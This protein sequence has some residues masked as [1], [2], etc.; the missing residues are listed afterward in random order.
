[1][2]LR[3][4]RIFDLQTPPLTSSFA[5]LEDRLPTRGGEWICGMNPAAQHL[6]C[7]TH[8]LDEYPLLTTPW[9][10]VY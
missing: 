8:V 4:R 7:V 1:M 10:S 9:A 6:K 2:R 3:L 5:A